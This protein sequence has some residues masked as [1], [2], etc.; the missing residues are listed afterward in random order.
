MDGIEIAGHESGQEAHNNQKK[1]KQDTV[2]MH[3]ITHTHNITNTN[4]TDT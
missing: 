4:H 1:Q 3:H 2:C